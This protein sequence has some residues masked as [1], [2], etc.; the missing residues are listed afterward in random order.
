M[1]NSSFLLVLLSESKVSWDT[2]AE[3]SQRCCQSTVELQETLCSCFSDDFGYIF[4]INLKLLSPSLRFYSTCDEWLLFPPVLSA[5]PDLS[6]HEPRELATLKEVTAWQRQDFR[7]LFKLR[8]T[9]KGL[10]KPSP[11]PSIAP[12]QLLWAQPLKRVIPFTH[13]NKP[14]SAGSG[15]GKYKSWTCAAGEDQNHRLGQNIDYN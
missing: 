3:T 8:L 5:V 6:P 10:L 12:Q 11:S 7:C 14:D 9:W 13:R 2:V 15:T 1:N 4:L